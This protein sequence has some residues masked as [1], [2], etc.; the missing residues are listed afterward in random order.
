MHVRIGEDPAA[1]W[2]G[3]SPLVAAADTS[4]TLA[5]IDKGLRQEANHPTGYV[6]PGPTEG[7]DDESFEGLKG[8]LG[9]AGR[10]HQ[11]CAHPQPAAG[12]SGSTA[13]RC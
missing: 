10:G 3:V 5:G 7:L 6:L 12:G 13:R 2:R 4:G 9:E 11:D 8:D 1:P